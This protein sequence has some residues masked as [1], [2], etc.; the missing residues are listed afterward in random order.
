MRISQGYVQ[1]L[2]D[3]EL[4]IVNNYSKSNYLVFLL[5][6]LGVLITAELNLLLVKRSVLCGGEGL[7]AERIAS[8]LVITDQSIKIELGAYGVNRNTWCPQLFDYSSYLQ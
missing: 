1:R 6:I 5:I 3:N 4:L 8:Y 2:R 7:I